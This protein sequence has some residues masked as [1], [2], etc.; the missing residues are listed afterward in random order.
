MQY[1]FKAWRS[2][3]YR[4]ECPTIPDAEF[5]TSESSARFEA[6]QLFESMKMDYPNPVVSVS[7]P[8]H[9]IL[10][11]VTKDGIVFMAD[12]IRNSLA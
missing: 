2:P 3:E 10:F 8:S 11:T 7:H 12:E 9:G 6:I 1:R 5:T 4:A